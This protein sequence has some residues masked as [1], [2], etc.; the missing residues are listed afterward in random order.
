MRKTGDRSIE[1]KV[2]L[3]E[4]YFNFTVEWNEERFI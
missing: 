3:L 2:E 4:N 1:V